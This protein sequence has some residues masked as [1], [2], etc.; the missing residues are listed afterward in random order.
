MV[1][2]YIIFIYNTI[3]IFK[4]TR[5]KTLGRDFSKLLFLN[6]NFDSKYNNKINSHIRILM[7]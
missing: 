2:K 7:N 1:T 5:I 4:Q 3:F 6:N